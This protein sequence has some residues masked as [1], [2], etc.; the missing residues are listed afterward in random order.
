MLKPLRLVGAVLLTAPM[1]AACVQYTVELD[2][3][4]DS[5]GTVRVEAILESRLLEVAEQAGVAPKRF[6]EAVARDAD[7]SFGL[8]PDLSERA[9][10]QTL[11]LQ[12]D[13]SCLVALEADFYGGWFDGSENVHIAVFSGEVDEWEVTLTNLGDINVEA[14]IAEF[15]Q[16]VYPKDILDPDVIR[17]VSGKI[18]LLMPGVP[19]VVHNA[20]RIEDRRFIWEF[21]GHELGSLP[22]NLRATSIAP[23]ADYSNTWI[24]VVML[25][26]IGLIT[27]FGA[28][29]VVKR[30]RAPAWETDDWHEAAAAFEG[31]LSPERSPTADEY[32]QPQGGRG[33]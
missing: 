27:A 28:T 9:T 20:D 1:A 3:N 19:G 2:F 31:V 7:W 6:C 4:D 13:G 17:D 24:V 16:G 11:E 32:Q 18:S 15:E 21:S 5:S 30:H 29:Y 25:V 23:A 14:L 22:P 12:A 8:A 26:T 33:P 10:L